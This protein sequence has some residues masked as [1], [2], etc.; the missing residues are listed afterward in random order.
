[1]NQRQAMVSDR[2]TRLDEPAAQTEEVLADRRMAY[3][4]CRLTLGL[5]IYIHGA[6]RILRGVQQ[7]FVVKFESQYATTILPVPIAHVALTAIPYVEAVVGGLLFIGLW[8]RWALVSGALL[9][10]ALVFGTA[11]R[12][13]WNALFIQMLYVLI[14][15]VLLS[16]RQYNCFSID[17]N[18]LNKPRKN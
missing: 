12:Q 1:M 4:I 11:I 15:F 9:M 6:G 18:F 7:N 10:M 17:T 14:Y 13:D 5:N 2:E 8:T 16:L 3:A